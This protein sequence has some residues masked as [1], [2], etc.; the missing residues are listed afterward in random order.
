MKCPALYPRL[1]APSFEIKTQVAEWPGILRPS[2][3]VLLSVSIR[4]FLQTLKS[5][6]GP[7]RALKPGRVFTEI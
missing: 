6:C 5:V 1:Q 3:L 4:N 2:C 7:K